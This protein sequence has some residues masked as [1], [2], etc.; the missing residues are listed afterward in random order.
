MQF[1]TVGPVVRRQLSTALRIVTYTVRILHE[2][3]TSHLYLQP[4]RS[5][6]TDSDLLHID[7]KSAVLWVDKKVGRVEQVQKK[8]VDFISSPPVYTP[9][10]YTPYFPF[11]LIFVISIFLCF[12]PPVR[13][14]PPL[15]VHRPFPLLNHHLVLFLPLLSLPPPPLPLLLPLLLLLSSSTR[16]SSSPGQV[17][18]SKSIYWLNSTEN[19]QECQDMIRHCSECQ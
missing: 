15:P 17:G 6:R 11:S 8:F 10:P 18:D 4:V 1:I 16:F 5:L 12:L 14:F 13:F 7:G 9:F 2:V 19:I 3:A